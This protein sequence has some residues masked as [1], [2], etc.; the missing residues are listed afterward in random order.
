[1]RWPVGWPDR[2]I[3]CFRSC[4]SITDDDVQVPYTESNSSVC[5]H[6][7]RDVCACNM[8]ASVAI[9]RVHPLSDVSARLLLGFPVV[10]RY[11]SPRAIPTGETCRIL[12]NSLCVCVCVS[13]KDDE[14]HSKLND[15]IAEILARINEVKSTHVPTDNEKWLTCATIQTLDLVLKRGTSTLA[16]KYDFRA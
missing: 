11:S 8:S 9:M 14:D 1:M 16:V 4:R 5:L 7:T 3:R 2:C 13:T 12:D 10:C 15:K 6:A